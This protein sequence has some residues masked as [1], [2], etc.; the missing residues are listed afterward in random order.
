MTRVE[1][2]HVL[3]DHYEGS[4]LLRVSRDQGRGP[5]YSLAIKSVHLGEKSQFLIFIVSGRL[6]DSCILE[7][8]KSM[9]E[10]IALINSVNLTK[11]LSTLSKWCITT[12]LTG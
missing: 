10:R 8:L 4:Y 12:A 3:K 2:E 11:N 1:A 9:W 7:S 5:E 6:E